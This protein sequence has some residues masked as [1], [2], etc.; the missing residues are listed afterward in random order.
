LQQKRESQQNKG[1]RSKNIYKGFAPG[2]T[3]DIAREEDI[4]WSS[5]EKRGTGGASADSGGDE[6]LRR[7]S[8]GCRGHQNP[9]AKM[10]GPLK[11]RGV[12]WG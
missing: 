12:P 2:M 4:N 1:E 5:G 8:S 9:K 11:A 10:G 6:L 3:I 7:Q